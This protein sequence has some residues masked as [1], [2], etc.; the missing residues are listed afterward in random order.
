MQH[1]TFPRAS[2]REPAAFTLVELIVVV[3]IMTLLMT[4]AGLTVPSSMATQQLGGVA[5]QLTSDLDH[6]ALMAQRDNQPVEVRFYRYAEPD[7]LGGEEF[8]AYQVAKLV[9]WKDDGRPEVEFVSDVQ[10]FTGGIVIM[11]DARYSTLTAKTAK[12]PG[13]EDMELGVEYTYV[14]Y[15]IRPDGRTNL[16]R[17]SKTVFTLVHE[18]P[19]GAPEALPADYRAVVLDPVTGEVTLY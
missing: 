15:Q 16:S 9:G 19:S 7:G 2:R 4:L 12:E 11:P 10:R 18:T 8:R 17:A 13:A 5:R 6:A 3:A 14:S 1:P